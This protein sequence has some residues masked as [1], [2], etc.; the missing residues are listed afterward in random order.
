MILSLAIFAF[1]AA[2]SQ[3]YRWQTRQQNYENLAITGNSLLN[4]ILS[5]VDPSGAEERDN[6]AGEMNGTIYRWQCSTVLA[7]RNSVNHSDFGASGRGLGNYTVF[8]DR[9][10]LSLER[11]LYQKEVDF[12]RSRYVRSSG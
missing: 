7:S 1:T 8:L 11:Q 4:E 6:G 2:L 3:A 12:Y 10:R 9:C 5:S